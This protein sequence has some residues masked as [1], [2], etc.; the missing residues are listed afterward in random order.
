MVSI[1]SR[2]V[3]GEAPVR[4]NKLY[5][6]AWRWHFYAGLYVIPFFIM[7]AITGM[8]MAWI[9]HIDGRDGERTAVVAQAS[10]LPVSAQAEAA[11]AAVPG[12]TLKQYVAPRSEELAAIFRVDLGEVATMVVVDP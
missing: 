6:A 5:L 8:A 7:L 4:T 3:Q 2:D 10:A 11:L 9:A 12:G 1:D